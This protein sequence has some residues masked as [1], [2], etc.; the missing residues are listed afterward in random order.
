MKTRDWMNSAGTAMACVL[1]FCFCMPLFNG[2]TAYA[3]RPEADVK[4]ALP[5]GDAVVISP[6]AAYRNLAVFPIR[7]PSSLGPASG[8]KYLTLDEGLKQGL[9]EVREVGAQPPPLVRPRPGA[10]PPPGQAVN[11]VAN[12]QR[13]LPNPPPP[14]GVAG[15]VNR[16]IVINHSDQKLLLLAGEMVVGGKQDRIVQKD[17]IVPPNDKPT[18]IDV[19]CVEQGR[20]TNTSAVFKNA[21]VSGFPGAPK[22]AVGGGIADPSVRGTAQARTEQQAVWDEV[23]K[24]NRALGAA[25]GQTTYQA[26]RTSASNL[27]HQE[28]YIEALEAKVSGKDVV[29]AIVAVNGKLIWLDQFASP[30]L[31]AKYW[32]K[33]LRS[34]VM[35]AI[36]ARPSPEL[37]ER[38]RWKLPT[39]PEAA[40]YLSDRAGNAK[41]EG[42]ESVFKLL[43]IENKEHVLYELSDIARKEALIVHV[44]KMEKK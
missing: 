34:Y 13:I 5:G 35:E 43:R 1:A 23:G 40:A 10:N 42:E 2:S 3:Q 24:K 11:Q 15:D 29:G 6:A 28:P 39:V 38:I 9:I 20:W 37:E 17:R 41:F 18:I 16:L 25:P 19:F 44:C 36:A 22:A 32:P 21:D 14:Q 30:A 33:L 31:F 7:R 8:E 4:V 12:Q 27:K 26:A